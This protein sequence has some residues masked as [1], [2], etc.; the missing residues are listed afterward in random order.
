[1][2]RRVLTAGVVSVV[3]GTA[4][5]SAPVASAT[6]AAP[7]GFTCQMAGMKS[8]P[9]FNY[10]PNVSVSAARDGAA[11]T[12]TVAS[13]S[14]LPPVVPAGIVMKDAEQN[15]S[16]ELKV[17]GAPVT[18]SASGTTDVNAPGGA[19]PMAVVG[20]LRGSAATEKAEVDVA[21]TGFKFDVM[22]VGGTCAPGAPVGL[23][24]VKVAGAPVVA[25]EPTPSETPSEAPVEAGEEKRSEAPEPTETLTPLADP[26]RVTPSAS[27]REQKR[28]E[29]AAL[30][31]IKQSTTAV[32]GGD[33]VLG[34]P[35]F[36]CILAPITSD[37]FYTGP[38]VLRAARAKEDSQQVLLRASF[39]AIP[40]IAPVAIEDNEMRVHARLRIDGEPVRM[41]AAMNVNA[42]KFSEVELPFLAGKVKSS[43]DEI[44]VQFEGFSFDLDPV[45][46]LAIS[47]DCKPKADTD[48]GM[49]Q[50][51]VGAM[52]DRIGDSD[53]RSATPAPSEASAVGGQPW[54]LGL[55][56]LAAVLVAAAALVFMQ[57][58][59]SPVAVAARDSS[60]QTSDQPQ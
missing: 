50:V 10:K 54:V 36:D 60:D 5:L 21:V 15:V 39:P 18:L 14:A 12:F 27:P 37:F 19:R 17:D 11:T 26:T 58:R 48:Y 2:I 56:A 59:R 25:D 34:N 1:M 53:E 13:L 38:V 24:T 41:S 30:R 31:E 6:G 20:N 46:G 23:G 44:A 4:V 9:P 57:R 22:G 28:L 47:A 43:A 29:R 8:A 40:A 52:H 55:W 7:V 35:L 32:A 33:P 42:G 49:V 45:N 51:G 16:I 3:V